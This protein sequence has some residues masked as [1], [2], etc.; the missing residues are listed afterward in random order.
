VLRAPLDLRHTVRQE[1]AWLS[2][3]RALMGVGG[4][5]VGC[6]ERETIDLIERG[7]D[8]ATALREIADRVEAEERQADK[9]RNREPSG[10][11]DGIVV[12]G[13]VGGLSTTWAGRDA[14]KAIGDIVG[15]RVE[16]VRTPP[17]GPVR[18]ALL[19]E[20]PY[21]E[22]A[23]ELLLMDLATSEFVR[24]RPTILVAPPGVGKSRLLRRLGELLCVPVARFDA[25]SAFDSS[26]GGTPRRWATGEPTF[27]LVAIK[28]HKVSNP[29]V[30]LDELDKSGGSRHNG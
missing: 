1:T 26:I 4:R 27:S 22:R 30:L 2:A 24:L 3:A 19:A 10:P 12:V 14:A 8:Y 11:P 18:A 16:R 6:R 15:R 13:D 28:T 21:A 23:I 20:L 17:L 25:A 29:I 5:P 7:H 9:R